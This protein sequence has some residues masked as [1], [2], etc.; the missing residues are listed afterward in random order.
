[1]NKQHYNSGMPNGRNL[2]IFGCR[3]APPIDTQGWYSGN[4]SIGFS[5]TGVD[6]SDCVTPKAFRETPMLGE[7]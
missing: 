2:D 3:N 1:M 6:T 5:G 4:S 7:C